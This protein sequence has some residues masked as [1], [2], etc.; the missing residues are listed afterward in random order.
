MPTLSG[1]VQCP[2]QTGE[3]EFVYFADAV[4][5]KKLWLFSPEGG[6][7]HTV[8]L[9]EALDSLGRIGGLSFMGPDT[10]ILSSVY[11]NRIGIMDLEGHCSKVMDLTAQLT[12]PDRLAYELWQSFTTP[13]MIGGTACFEVRLVA[14]ST[15]GYE[16]RDAP[17][18]P[19]VYRYEWLARNGPHFAAFDLRRTNVEPI[20]RW[21]PQEPSI[22]TIDEIPA[23]AG[24]G[25][26]A[27][28][29]ER[30]FHFSAYSSVVS[31]L[32]LATMQPIRQFEVSSE[33]G[34]TLQAPIIIPKN[35]D[36]YLQDSL[37]D[38]LSSGGHIM[39]IRYDIPTG[40]YLVIV[41]HHASRSAAEQT[42]PA[43]ADF[44]V[45]EFDSAYTLVSERVFTDGEHYL[46]AMLS[47]S[48]GTYTAR[49]Q[50]KRDWMR[51]MPT[52]D[53]IILHG[54]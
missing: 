9:N 28:V 20:L 50:S 42:H 47:L 44:S 40:H 51:G 41:I 46:P 19:G 21:G 1:A 45:F 54:R 38:R 27:C 34:P 29:N 37:D 32:D 6:L 39:S 10:I 26:Y 49:V 35:S 33:I 14:E 24:V 8:P 17:Q 4:T 16:G 12:R 3:P 48:S 52:F 36:F 2:E 15:D 22:D 25:S 18:R 53:R 7:L 23:P 5:Q 11:S 13:F 31:V 30:W 43:D